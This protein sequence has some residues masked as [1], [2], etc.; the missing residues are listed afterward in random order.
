MKILAIA[1][2]KGGVGKTATVQSLGAALSQEHGLDV[3]M[4]DAD[5]QASLTGACGI[6]GAEPS[7]ADVVGGASP[8]SLAISDILEQIKPGL[9]LAPADISLSGSELGLVS[10]M[11]RENV[12]K[13]ALA[14]VSEH[15]D[16]ALIDCPPSLG[17]LTL[18][19]LTAADAV[20][21]P[22]QPSAVDLRGLRLFFDTLERIR[23]ELNPEL[24][25]LGVL[26][27]FYQD[28]LNHHQTALEALREAG[29]PVL[30][31]TIGRTVRVAEAAG[32][33]LSVIEYAPDNPR[34]QE[35]LELSNEVIK[36]L[37]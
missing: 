16:I 33:A 6:A 13:K 2:Q 37:K 21:I 11:G 10:R 19:A 18:N 14:G 17:L 30:D 29:L 4:V 27:T 9:Y 24:E 34:T 15:F 3:L 8:G 7:L 5:P 22:C 23:G 20:L 12:I 31:V 25:T 1:N 26:V 35:Y 32:E 28:R 36:W